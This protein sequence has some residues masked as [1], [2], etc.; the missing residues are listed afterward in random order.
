[1]TETTTLMTV[2]A[3]DFLASCSM[4][5]VLRSAERRGQTF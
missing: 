2:S 1:V 3:M 5:A 4:A